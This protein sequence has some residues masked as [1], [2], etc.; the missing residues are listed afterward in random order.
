MGGAQNQSCFLPAVHYA[1]GD[2]GNLGIFFHQQRQEL[3][4]LYQKRTQGEVQDDDAGL[5]DRNFFQG[6]GRQTSV[7]DKAARRQPL[8]KLLHHGILEHYGVV[9]DENSQVLHKLLQID[10]LP[11]YN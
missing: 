6:F 11:L 1:V 7:L 2:N 9:D 8:I 3:F 5:K 10:R 4:L